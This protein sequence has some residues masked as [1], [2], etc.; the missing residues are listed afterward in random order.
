M[1]PTGAHVLNDQ[2]LFEG[3]CDNF[4]KVRLSQKE[5][6]IRGLSISSVAPFFILCFLSSWL[7]TGSLRWSHTAMISPHNWPRNTEPHDNGQN[8]LRLWCREMIFCEVS[9]IKFW[10][11]NIAVS[12]GRKGSSIVCMHG[13]KLGKG[14]WAGEIKLQVTSLLTAAEACKLH[15]T[16]EGYAISF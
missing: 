4:K 6:L 5:Q 3:A 11:I 16:N 1:F 15:P 14:I 7:W 10:H 2:I 9:E 8:L 13:Y 12:L